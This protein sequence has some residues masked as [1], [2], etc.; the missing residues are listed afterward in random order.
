MNLYPPSFSREDEERFCGDL[1]GIPLERVREAF[2]EI[3]GDFTFSG[4][5]AERYRRFRPDSPVGL[6]LGRFSVWYVLVRLSRPR[7]VLETGVH[8][9][10]SSALILHAMRRN[11][12]GRLISI[13]LP[14]V[15]LPPQAEGPGWLVEDGLRP[16]WTLHLGDVR[17]LL[18][19]LALE[20]SPL[21]I[22]LHDSDHSREVQEFEYRTVLPHLGPHGLLV[23]D[24]AQ[25][26]LINEIA[27]ELSLRA[28]FAMG[29]EPLARFALG[30]I[31]L[32]GGP[33]GKTRSR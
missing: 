25:A 21:D 32:A 6:H 12:S 20:N 24:D 23:S 33:Q 3:D 28:N 10:L 13:D 29:A 15:D 16:R 18:P 30:G 22:F 2:K 26:D 8:D 11:G 19:R 7:V 17:K 4:F 27:G 1:L 14:S 5:L 31:R 9:G